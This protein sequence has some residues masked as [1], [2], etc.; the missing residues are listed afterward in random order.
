MPDLA[1]QFVAGLQATA[2]A[3]A[4]L[5]GAAVALAPPAIVAVLAA[6]SAEPLVRELRVRRGR[7]RARLLHGGG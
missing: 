6:A 2:A 7:R 5:L 3:L 4:W 1:A